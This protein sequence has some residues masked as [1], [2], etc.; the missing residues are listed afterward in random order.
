[1]TTKKVGQL[2]I[3][4]PTDRELAMTRVFDA[5]PH[6]V[7]EAHVR[8]DLVKRWLGAFRG[9]SLAV[10]EIDL[11]VGGAARYVWRNTDGREMGMS[12]VYREIVPNERI[13]ASEAFDEPWYEGEAV[14]T[15]TFL[16]QG[17][18]T[19]FTQTMR[20]ATR[21]IRDAVLAS[22]METGVAASYDEL[23]KLLQANAA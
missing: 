16:E 22:P 5:P 21:Q 10:C 8:P 6:L 20:Y 13:V 4:T 7:Y 14:G 11:R 17:G 9:W 15:I 19:T 23:A 2:L 12:S 3:T 18:K 1:V